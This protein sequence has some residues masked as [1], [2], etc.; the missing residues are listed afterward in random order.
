VTR[1]PRAQSKTSRRSLALIDPGVNAPLCYLYLPLYPIE[2][3]IVKNNYA[4]RQG[5][6]W[7]SGLPAGTNQTL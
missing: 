1:I 6:V 5:G 4:R 2:Y 3:E 7:K